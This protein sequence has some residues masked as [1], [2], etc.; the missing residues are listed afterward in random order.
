MRRGYADAGAARAWLAAGERHD[1][2][3]F[4]GI[5]DVCAHV[6]EHVRARTRI[7]VHGDYDVDGVC[8][9]A[10]LVGVLR[11]LG[12]DVDWFLPSRA[13]DGYGLSTATVQRLAT[14]G[15][16][17]LIT[18]DCAITAVDE[19]AAALT[20]GIDVVVTDHHSPRADGVLPAA[21][22][23]HPAVCGYPCVDLCAA[24]VAYKLAGALLSAAGEDPGLADRDL[25]LVALATIADCVPLR[26]ENRRLVRAGLRAMAATKRPGLRALMRV[27]RA[28]PARIDTTAVGFRLAPRINAAGRLERADAGLELL[29]TADEIRAAQIADELDRLN[30]ERRMT[31]TRI[32][33]EAEAMVA[34]AEPRRAALLL[35]PGGRGLAQGR[36]RDRR[37][38]DRRAP[39][40]P[41][42]ARRTGSA[43]RG[44]HGLG[45]LDPRLRPAR[46]PGRVGRAPDAPRRPPRRGRLRGARVEDRR[47]PRSVRGP[48]RRDS[49]A[50][51]PR[52]GAARRRRRRRRRARPAARRGAPAPRAVRHRQ[53]RR[54]AAR[55]GRPLQ[56]PAH[57]GG[58]R[59]AHALHR[60]DGRRHRARRRLRHRR[61][62]TASTRSTRRSRSRS[63]STT[64]ASS[65]ACCCAMRGPAHRTRS[66]S[67]ASPV[68]RPARTSPPRSPRRD[69]RWTTSKSSPAI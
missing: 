24:G 48:R 14:R 64:A 18:A 22:I 42:R 54:H 33:F 68:R 17:L 36:D 11:T 32:L 50:R 3:Q 27:A 39:P 10:I 69:A 34:E 59:Q 49:H 60:R 23:V 44:R 67:S 35:R 8:S 7:T 57:D 66:S 55:A 41:D 40:P 65:R 31:E 61:R 6:L 30:S 52:R 63:T 5:E 43:D 2:S 28:D 58:G 1:P 37:L 12:A 19:V 25:D 4:A 13:E 20:A 53:P 9:T 15:T 51:G 29:L 16:K 38:A 21:P 45:A 62:S 56:R 26:G 46:R 47:V